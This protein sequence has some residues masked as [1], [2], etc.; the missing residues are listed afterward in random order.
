MIE[1][2]YQITLAISLSVFT[3]PFFSVLCSVNRGNFTLFSKSL[4]RGLFSKTGCIS[5]SWAME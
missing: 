5:L 4:G 3:N 1:F 2:L